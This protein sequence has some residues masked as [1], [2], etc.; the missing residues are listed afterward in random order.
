[1]ATKAVPKTVK[2]RLAIVEYED[3]KVEEYN[4]GKPIYEYEITQAGINA[5][6][7]SD[8]V[9]WTLWLAAGKPG[10]NGEPLNAEKDRPKMAAWIATLAAYEFPDAEDVPPTTQRAASRT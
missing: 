2:R 8:S 10:A 7:S 3:G 4:L 6:E 9:F 1:M 5:L